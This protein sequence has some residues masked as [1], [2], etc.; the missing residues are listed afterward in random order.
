MVIS[1]D[2]PTGMTRWLFVECKLSIDDDVFVAARHALNDLL[3]YRGA[4][5]VLLDDQPQPHG[6][7]LAWGKEL[8]PNT[9]SEITLATPDTLA[10]AVH[11]IVH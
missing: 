10:S 5:G 11:S 2:A 4:F 3:A 6:L 8:A 7:G 9:A 1:W